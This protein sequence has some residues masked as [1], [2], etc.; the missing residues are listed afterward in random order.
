MT[1]YGGNTRWRGGKASCKNARSTEN[2]TCPQYATRGA[3]ATPRRNRCT[4]SLCRFWVRGHRSEIMFGVLV[5]VLCPDCVADQGLGT[6]ERQIA[7]IVS[8]RISRPVR[9]GAAGARCPPLGVGG[10]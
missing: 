3:P 10:A 4:K 5:V 9:L 1:T 2:R 7:L 6:G 8:L